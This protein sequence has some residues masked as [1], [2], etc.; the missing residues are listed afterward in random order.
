MKQSL[1]LVLTPLLVASAAPGTYPDIEDGWL[2]TPEV[3]S[4]ETVK[5]VMIG[6]TRHQVYHQLGEP[7]F[8]EGI[9]ARTWNYMFDLRSKGQAP[10]TPCAV[11]L[12]YEAGRVERIQWQTESCANAAK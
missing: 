6:M 3:I 5:G 12:V 9:R 2:D 7:H 1:L 10:G 4:V 8:N 11:Q